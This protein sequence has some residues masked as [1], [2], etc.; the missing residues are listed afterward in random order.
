MTQSPSS[1]PANVAPFVGKLP[2]TPDDFQLEAMGH[3]ADGHSVV[4]CAPTGSGK[5]LIAEFAVD[6]ALKNG[7]RIFYTTP[8]KALSNQKYRDLQAEYGAEKVGLLTGDMSANRDAPIVVMTTEIFRNMLYTES[9]L[10]G[11]DS[12]LL[13]NVQYVVL[14]E[15]HYMNDAQ[16]GT[17]WEESVIYCPPHMQLIALSATV[18][19]ADELTRWIDYIHPSCKLV[20]SDFRPVP[21]QIYY[22]DREKIS[23]LFEHY[24][25]GT[26]RSQWKVNGSLKPLP[27]KQR[28]SKNYRGRKPS[29]NPKN[30]REY[31]P[32]EFV[33]RMAAKEMLPAIVF[34]FSRGG[35]DKALKSCF[36]LNLNSP[37]E[38]RRADAIIA[39]MTEDQQYVCDH[40]HL[41]FLRQG[42]ASHHAGLLPGLK[43]LVEKLFQENLIK[44]VFATE[45][46]AAG[47]NM[48]ARTTV[49]TSLSKRTDDG[50]RQLHASE[51][52]QMAGRAGRRGMDTMGHV[53]VLGSPF[54]TPKDAA[55]VATSEPEALN[56]QFTPTYGMVLNLLQRGSLE[57]AQTLVRKS[58][59]QFTWQRRLEPLTDELQELRAQE[60]HYKKI[61]SEAGLDE[62]KFLKIAKTRGKLLDAYRNQRHLRR[63]LKNAKGDS[64]KPVV[65]E[66]K[67]LQSKIG[68]YK[69]RLKDAPVDVDAFF[70]KHK[71]LDEKLA[72]ARR[73]CRRVEGRI[74]SQ[75]DIYWQQFMGIYNLLK[76]RNYIDENDTPTFSGHLT[77]QLRTENPLLVTEIILQG[78]LDN[79]DPQSLAGLACSIIF[80]SNR[81]NIVCKFTYAQ[82]TY[83]RLKT[84][85][86]VAKSVQKSQ[87]HH[88]VNLPVVIN[89][90]ISGLCEAW[91]DGRDWESLLEGTSL[92]EGDIVRTM[93]RC[94]DILRQW[95]HLKGVDPVF[96]DNAFKAYNAIQKDPVKEDESMSVMVESATPPAPADPPN[97]EGDNSTEDTN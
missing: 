90:A 88:G 91:A 11:A 40:P 23:P 89:P 72:R 84:I 63:D 13:D 12:G 31:N 2:F 10:F 37:E 51:F 78:L 66:L 8:L 9:E 19:N 29:S 53:I 55:H 3:L 15:C 28:N 87:H 46:L 61:L 14:D 68:E 59:G 85:T 17:V 45:T 41:A 82:A 70:S 1:V 74:K 52:L 50:H 67:S 44:V 26:P 5:T 4:V 73:Y 65:R 58:F 54:D 96:A 86:E 24:A 49:I 62:E 76:E 30:V 38:E 6:A 22:D 32:A 77:A 92:A 42:I 43:L 57:A 79:L 95:S 16:R 71:K 48:P 56:S 64:G 7:Q 25:P 97:A 83:E 20:S 18:A 69:K 81:D 34:T 75:E 80:D 94:S 60:N 39:E 36:R 33:Q 27:R 35:C 21:L 47:I 93:R